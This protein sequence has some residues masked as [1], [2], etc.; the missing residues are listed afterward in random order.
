MKKALHQPPREFREAAA[1]PGKERRK[2]VNSY[3]SDGRTMSWSKPKPWPKGPFEHRFTREDQ[4]L[5]HGVP[6]RS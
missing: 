6:P 1:L 5:P 2:A 3:S 4:Q